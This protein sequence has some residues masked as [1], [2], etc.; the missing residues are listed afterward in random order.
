MA[1]FQAA[2]W[3]EG[4]VAIHKRT[5]VGGYD[6]PTSPF[7]TP[8]A[9]SMIQRYPMMAIGTLDDD[10]RPWCTVWGSDHLPIAQPVAQSV[11]GV[12]TTVDASFDPVVQAIYKGKDD[13]E[14]MRE[15]GNGRLMAGLSIHLEERG[16]VKV[17]GQVIAGAL[18]VN[19]AVADSSELKGDLQSGRS[20][21]VQLVVKIDQSLGNCPK[22]LNKKHIVAA[23][24]KP[25]LLS[26][27][28][29][30]TQ[31][32]IDLV[33]SADL[34]FV[35]STHKHEDMDCNHRGGPP[36]FI[37]VQQPTNSDEGSTI[38]WPEYSGNNLYQTLGNL[39]STP[40]AGL[41]IPDFETGD[42]LYVT[43]D[44]ETLVGAAASKVITKSNLAVSLK[45]TAARLVE[46][47][48]PFRGR[49]MD[50]ASQGRSPY[51]PRVR[52]LTSEKTDAFAKTAGDGPPTTAKLIK[53]T[54]I[55]PTVTRYRF[56]LADP[57]VFGPWK[58]G[59]YVAMDL[60]AEMD[61][62]YSHMR[63]DDPTSLNDDYIRTF[64]VSSIPNSLG[65][66]GEEFEV[67]VRKV[68]NVTK[69]LE[70]QREGMC[71]IGIRGF[72]GEF[73]FEPHSRNAFIAAG[74]G[75][76][77]LLGQMESLDLDKLKVSWSVGIRDV[78]LPLDILTQYPGL[79]DSLTICLT[80]DE[81]LLD[82]EGGKEK[83]KLQEL[84]DTGVQVLRR[85]VTKEDL[86][87]WE[88]EVDNWYLCT[89]PAMRKIVQEW[90]PGTTIVYENFDY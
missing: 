33:Q 75:I 37:R 42:V 13:G 5:R 38:V 12:R 78:A 72:G 57:G 9:A 69:W 51:N 81:S 16:R 64:T 10:G 15:E 55:T 63:D 8:R 65:L 79:K 66:H 7:L 67:T 49:L 14:V 29:H 58:P 23:D 68:G 6:N 41:V 61:M 11:M 24:P 47:G 27:S 1:F 45:V 82:G 3:H 54:K 52:Y 50:D 59:Q 48:L 80:G 25:R 90:M 71:E 28:P 35:T 43:G 26:S 2:S 87:V 22:Y 70:W 76:T 39:E 83:A 30:L 53:K 19:D 46:N 20:G 84:L 74:I 21:E 89:A 17:A 62:G 36:G 60:A 73:V 86:V 88:T 4:E 18:T 31:K 40:H 85:R 32:A 44:T 56:A 34:F 77:P